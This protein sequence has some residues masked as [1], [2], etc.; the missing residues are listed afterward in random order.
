MKW[1]DEKCFNCGDDMKNCHCG[2]TEGYSSDGAVCPYCGHID[3]ADESEGSL[4][5]DYL[6][7]NHCPSCNKEYQVDLYISYSWTTKRME[8]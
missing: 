5:D 4:Y 6:E 1:I 8:S 2:D 3:P 7:Y